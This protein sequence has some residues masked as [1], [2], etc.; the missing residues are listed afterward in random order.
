MQVTAVIRA[1]FSA[2]FL[3][4]LM[5]FMILICRCA[6]QEIF[7]IIINV[8]KCCAYYIF[9]K[10]EPLLLIKYCNKFLYCHFYQFNAGI[11]IV[12]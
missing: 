9:Q 2:S 1:D 12:E 5:I 6:A 3:Q 4:R 11:I 10:K 8:E 7:L